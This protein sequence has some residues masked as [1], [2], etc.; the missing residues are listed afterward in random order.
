MLDTAWYNLER[1]SWSAAMYDLVTGVAFGISR[2]LF[3]VLHTATQIVRPRFAIPVPFNQQQKQLAPEEKNATA[4][5]RHGSTI[6]V[7]AIGFGRTGT[8]SVFK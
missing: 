2:F 4:C 7:A 5:Q 3:V 6:K 1:D 8:V